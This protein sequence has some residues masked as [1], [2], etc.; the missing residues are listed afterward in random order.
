MLEALTPTRLDKEVAA[1]AHWIRVRRPARDGDRA[2]TGTTRHWLRKLPARRRPLR[3]CVT[4]PRVAN[5][6]AWCWAD[7]SMTQQVL[8]DLT[9]DRRGG[10]RGFPTGVMRE[11]R[12]LR[13]FNDQQRIEV[14]PET[15]LESVLR[16]LA[17]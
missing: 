5:R 12:R 16:L 11:L 7:P 14:R 3:L 6:I 15:W 1:A 9:H 10:R 13:E 4:F 8:D 17:W 2:L